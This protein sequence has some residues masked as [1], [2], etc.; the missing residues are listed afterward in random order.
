MRSLASK[1]LHFFSASRVPP[2]GVPIDPS[3]TLIVDLPQQIHLQE[4]SADVRTTR[5]VS[6]RMADVKMGWMIVDV[7][8][9]AVGTKTM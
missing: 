1:L 3:R 9:A 2:A 5:I 4:S 7:K 8:K 6:G